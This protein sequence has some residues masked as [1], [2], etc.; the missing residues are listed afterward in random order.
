[1]LPTVTEVR[2]V[3]NAPQTFEL[4]EGEAQNLSALGKEL[5]SKKTWWGSKASATVG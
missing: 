5:A 3:E 2:A 4:T 1:M